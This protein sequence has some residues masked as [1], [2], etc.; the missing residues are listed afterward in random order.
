[1]GGGQ[2]SSGATSSC[3]RRGS[4]HQVLIGC[5]VGSV[6][7]EPIPKSGTAEQAGDG[8]GHSS[9]CASTKCAVKCLAG[10]AWG[11]M[12]RSLV[13][14][15]P[16]LAMATDDIHGPERVAAIGA[17]RF[18]RWPLLLLTVIP[19]MHMHVTPSRVKPLTCGYAFWLGTGWSRLRATL[20]S[21]EGALR[22]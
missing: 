5:Q 17:R 11:A 22:T 8:L 10:P 21:T 4:V 13:I 20:E 15:L 18:T 14:D 9:V 12:R 16:V 3:D 1:M 6:P 19:C 7:P 2:Q